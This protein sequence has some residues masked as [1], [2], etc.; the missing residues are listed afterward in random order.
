MDRASIAS[1][2]ESISKRTDAF[3]FLERE[4]ASIAPA[5]LRNELLNCGIIPE[6]FGHDS[7]EEKL[8]A[9]YCDIILNISFNVLDI[10]SEVIRVR[11]DSADI[12]GIAAQYSIVADAKAFRLS[13]TAK[14]QKDF[15]IASLD[16]WRR[17][18]TYA[19]LVAPI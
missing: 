9:K 14:N 11:G 16:D 1:L 6:R 2:I 5:E 7:S 8:W 17:E 19:C 12:R 3:D 10:E 15:K 13:R 18:N 4:L